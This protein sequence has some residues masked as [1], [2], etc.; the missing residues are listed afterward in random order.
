MIAD[1]RDIIGEGV[2][3]HINHMLIVKIHRNPP[4]KRGSGNTQILQSRQ[5]EIVHHFILAGNRL[6]KFGMAVD[7][8]NQP[9]RILA[10]LKEVGFFLC[11]L[12]LAPAVR[13]LA[14][15]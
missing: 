3:P 12:H 15:N 6:Y 14:V 1:T 13:A 9:V 5:K 10:H 7:V 11:R 4:F 2:K 8:R